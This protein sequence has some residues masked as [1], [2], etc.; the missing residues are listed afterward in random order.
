MGSHTGA[1][2]LTVYQA[3]FRILQHAFVQLQL[4]N[5]DEF[6]PHIY[7]KAQQDQID[8]ESRGIKKSIHNNL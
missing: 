1:V 5:L 7:N 4:E 2:S 6:L 8:Q 3:S